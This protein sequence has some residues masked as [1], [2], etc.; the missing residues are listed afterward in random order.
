MSDLNDPSHWGENGLVAAVTV[1]GKHFWDKWFDAKKE[2]KLDKLITVVNE[3]N[4]KVQV[5]AVSH[6]D[7]ATLKNDLSKLTERHENL[8]AQFSKLLGKMGANVDE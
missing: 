2:E 3:M 5:M 7:I 8:R 4:V 1:A 6:A